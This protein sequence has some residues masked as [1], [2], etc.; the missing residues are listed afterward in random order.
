MRGRLAGEE[1]D[2]GRLMVA[3]DL[4]GRGIGRVLLEAIE[5]AAPDEATG[6]SLFTGALSARNIRLYQK[7]GYRLLGPADEAPGAVRLVKRR[8]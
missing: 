3:P 6:Y 7:A 5:A 2:V 4:Q 1:W 8:R